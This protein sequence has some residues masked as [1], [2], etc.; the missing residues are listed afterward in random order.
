MLFLYPNPVI[1]AIE[2]KTA[3]TDDLITVHLC[4]A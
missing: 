1:V 3:C 4:I 2:R